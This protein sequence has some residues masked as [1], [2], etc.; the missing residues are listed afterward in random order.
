MKIN[1]KLVKIILIFYLFFLNQ[2][3]AIENKILFKV[4][5]QI[6]T[7][8]DVLNE[9]NYLSLINSDFQ[10]LDKQKIYEVSKNSLIR[11]KIKEINLKKQFVE[12]KLNEEYLNEL[13]KDYS[14]RVG[15]KN[16][17]DFNIELKKNNIKIDSVIKKITIEAFWN[18]LIIDKFLKNVKIN[19]AG[20]KKELQNQKIQKEYLL[21]EI[22]FGLE[23]NN[24]LV[25]KMKIIKKTISDEGFSKA[26]LIH[27][28]SDTSNS[29]GKLDWINEASLNIKIKSALNNLEVGAHTEPILLPGGYLIL[30]INDI[31]EVVKEINFEKEFEKVKRAKTNEQ[32]NIMSNL[33][34][35]KIKKNIIINEL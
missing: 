32:L 6:I 3:T 26:A 29:G 24:E 31:K 9:I 5:N 14:R 11:E 19:E 27:S 33:Y 21:S 25:N 4:N 7:S 22:L 12:L 16:T 15:F 18:Q 34:F 13:I 17:N 1:K 10:K 30:K 8:I 35:N 2:S 23:N 28:I 20:I